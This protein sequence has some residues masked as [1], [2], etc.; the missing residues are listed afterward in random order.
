M[1]KFI[2]LFLTIF[3]FDVQM[4]ELSSENKKN[5]DYEINLDFNKNNLTTEEII[6][7]QDIEFK[8]MLAA[9][10]DS[11]IIRKSMTKNLDKTNKNG[12]VL[13]GQ[14]LNSQNTNNSLAPLSLDPQLTNNFSIDESLNT[15]QVNE[16]NVSQTF[17]GNVPNC[18]KNLKDNDE[19]S[20]ILKEAIAVEDNEVAKQNLLKRYAQ[21]N[22]LDMEKMECIKK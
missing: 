10:D 21:Y 12:D 15:I 2:F 8:K 11:C 6:I 5:C 9:M 19:V 14:E 7:L 1:N 13:K 22:N 16:N 4:S 20:K 3:I 17:T 18:I